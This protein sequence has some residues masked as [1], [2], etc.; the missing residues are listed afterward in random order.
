[1]FEQEDN[2]VITKLEP[3]DKNDKD[4]NV[5]ILQFKGRKGTP[6]EPGVYEVEMIIPQTYPANFPECKFLH[7]FQHY[8]VFQNGSICLFL[9]KNGG[10]NA[11][12]HLK[13]LAI[14]LVNMIHS[15]PVP[16]DHADNKMKDI[17]AKNNG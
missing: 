17:F 13:E 15:D 14:T 7:G 8:H 16:N 2:G 10:W 4:M 9:L 6:F 12:V 5:W 3:R 11:K 1:M